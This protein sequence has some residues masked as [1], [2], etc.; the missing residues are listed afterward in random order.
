[1]ELNEITGLIVD[2]AIE[3]HS[4]L[5]PGLL[6]EAYKQCLCEELLLRGLKVQT[7]VGLP[8]RYKSTIVDV[9]YRVDLVVE[10]SVFVE[11]KAVHQLAPI[12]QAQLFTY[13]KLADKPLGQLLNFN[14]RL[15][16]NGIVRI[17]V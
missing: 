8:V 10:H 17:K 1:M 7:E 4:G 2:A 9:G 16:K 12:H 11:L 5:G 6:E 13:L 3:V 14:V 15:M